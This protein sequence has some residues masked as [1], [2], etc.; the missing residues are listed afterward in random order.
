MIDKGLHIAFLTQ[1]AL[2]FKLRHHLDRD[3]V[4]ESSCQ[5]LG[6]D[7]QAGV[8]ALGKDSQGSPKARAV[9]VVAQAPISLVFPDVACL[10]LGN[11]LARISA[12]RALRTLGLSFKNVR[13]LSLPW[14]KRSPL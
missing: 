12:S 14:P 6:L 9:G 5:K 4:G 3:L 10:A 8:L 7:F 11:A 13:T 1:N 2:I